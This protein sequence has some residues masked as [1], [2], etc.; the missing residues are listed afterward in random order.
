[1]R[2]K[3]ALAGLLAVAIAILAAV[4][5]VTAQTSTEVPRSQALY[6]RLSQDAA[7]GDVEAA[8]ARDAIDQY[9]V[10]N[11][12]TLQDLPVPD[13]VKN[14]LVRYGAVDLEVR[15][16]APWSVTVRNRTVIDSLDRVNAYKGARH[17]ALA[18]LAATP[19][20]KIEV[21]ITPSNLIPV[22]AFGKKVGV[23]PTSIIVDA[24][25]GDEWVMSA[26]RQVDGSVDWTKLETDLREQISSSL[27]QYP[28]LA[29]GDLLITV[30][31]VRAE[32]PASRAQKLTDDPGI[33]LVDPLTDL[34][35]M[36]ANKAAMVSV[37]DPPDVFFLYATQALH[38]PMDSKQRQPE[39]VEAQP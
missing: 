17:D 11:G 10:R 22:A 28:G 30:R 36:Y 34:A 25:A 1:M 32:L 39:K 9:L 18:S 2:R 31:C 3:L 7:K 38:V 13:S 33:L 12:G 24:F 19:S 8:R 4:P 21:S 5:I 14:T 23:R 6:D 15:D 20:R 35:D 27:D 26:R 16:A 29:A 37:G